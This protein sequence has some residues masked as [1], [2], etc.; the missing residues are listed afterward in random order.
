MFETTPSNKLDRDKTYLI[1]GT[2]SQILLQGSLIKA[3][4]EILGQ[5]LGFTI[6]FKT[7]FTDFEYEFKKNPITGQNRGYV[8]EAEESIKY[9]GVLKDA[10]PS[11]EWILPREDA[12]ELELE[13]FHSL[14][15]YVI[16]FWKN[17]KN[18]DEFIY[19]TGTM[20]ELRQQ[21]LDAMR[22]NNSH[23]DEIGKTSISESQ[24]L[25]GFPEIKLRFWQTTKNEN[26]NYRHDTELSITLIGYG[27]CL[28]D[29][30]PK[31]LDINDLKKFR[32][33]IMTLFFPNNIPFILKRGKETYTY[34]DWKKGYA[35]YTHF[36]NE[37]NAIETY[38]LL[39]QIKG[40]AFDENKVGIGLKLNDKQFNDDETI[41]VMNKQVKKRNYR[42]VVDL[43]F[44]QAWVWLP[45]SSK[46]I[47][48]FNRGRGLPCDPI[49]ND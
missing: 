42:P 22:D 18:K 34:Q 20:I 43:Q 40:D 25:S 37:Q 24:L 7:W 23:F 39:V 19:I 33:K 26:K 21:C 1:S 27:E 13:S 5:R 36:L 12:T 15:Y 6:D 4:H 16:K 31:L 14:G 9:W 46:K 11:F 8:N 30:Q 49:F 3:L 28:E 10:R 47:M 38:K 17:R 32:E 2:E 41:T 29:N 48:L 44:W 35:N 45:K